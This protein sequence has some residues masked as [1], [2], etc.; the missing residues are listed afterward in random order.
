[1]TTTPS[2]TPFANPTIDTLLAHR[3]IRRFADA[4][5]P[6][7]HVRLAVAAGQQASTSSNVQAYSILRVRETTTRERLVELTGGQTKVAR[8]GAFFVVS[9]DTRRH[10]LLATRAAVP[11]RTRLE[12]F[13]VAAIDASLFAQ[14]LC[15]A[16]E[17]LG[18]GICY[19]GGLRND[20]PGVRDL[21]HVPH[22]V[23]PLFGLCV[24][25][26]DESPT[27]RPRLAPEAVLH[28]DRFPDDEAI[29]ADAD[30][31]DER[32]RAWYAERGLETTWSQR[33]EKQFSE[34]HRTEVARFYVEQ[35]AEL[36]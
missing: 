31:Y 11:H 20:L 26:P 28:E 19:I 5:V 33:I 16:F 34:A 32:M 17:S 18:Y 12:G 23:Y 14:N 30:A 29:L 10:R 22:G 36:D 9:G 24:G 8:C 25:V 7:E 6:D 35:G 27:P 15:V 1:M 2:A 4:P 21:L 13:L 3:S